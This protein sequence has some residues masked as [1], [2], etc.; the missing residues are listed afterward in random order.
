M[1]EARAWL[2]LCPGLGRDTEEAAGGDPGPVT[3]SLMT[4]FAAEL[5]HQAVVVHSS[6]LVLGVEGGRLT[7]VDTSGQPVPAPAVAYA[8]LSTPRLS[9]DREV[10]LLRHL[11]TMGTRLINPAEAVLVAVNKFWQL[12]R[13]AAAGIPVP[14]T[15]THTDAP[16]EHVLDV[17][18]PEPCVVKAVRGHRGRRVFLAADEKGLRA[19]AGSLDD[20]HPYLLQRYVAHSHGRDL[21][22]I[23]V[24]RR[25]VA[26]AVRTAAD[27]RLVSNLAQGGSHTVCTGRYPEA[28]AL[29]VRAA[30]A[31]GLGVAGV[32]LLFEADGSFT[33]CEVN[34]NPTWRP[35]MLG[36]AEAVAV[37]CRGRLEAAG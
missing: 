7:L 23:V 21:R 16:L 30:D 27:D 1:I 26:A 20:R 37:A 2:L 25:A 22:V 18:V 8:R 24:D 33:V 11:A 31:I 4:A 3:S 17:G 9:A 13:L 35:D 32:D 6:R 34:C 19:V 15:R 29:A 28:E 12:Q 36:V 5:G 10:T 14:D